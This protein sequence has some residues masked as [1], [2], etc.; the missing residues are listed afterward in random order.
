MAPELLFST[1]A[2]EQPPAAVDALD[3]A[4]VSPREV[5]WLLEQGYRVCKEI[6][7]GSNGTVF[8]AVAV[9]TGTPVALKMVPVAKLSSNERMRL[10]REILTLKNVRHRG[11]VQFV[12][13]L[14][15]DSHVYIVTELMKEDLFERTTRRTLTEREAADVAKQIL[16]TLRFLHRRGVY[17]RDIKLENIMVAE[18]DD[19]KN[20]CVKLVDFGGVHISARHVPTDEDVTLQTNGKDGFGTTFYLPPEVVLQEDYKP[21]AVDV[22]G[23]GVV[24]YS[25]MT[26]HFPFYGSSNSM[27]YEMIVKREPTFEEPEWRTVSPHFKQFLRYLLRK[28][29]T[30]RATVES[31][32]KALGR[33]VSVT[34]DEPMAVFSPNSVDRRPV[35]KTPP[36][37]HPKKKAPFN[38]LFGRR[39][40]SVGG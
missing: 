28:D 14:E 12:E 29:D 32:L 13:A 37:G 38:G 18:S 35:S 22:W 34:C 6:A 21:A 8:R 27:V 7:A 26:G 19:E 24:L 17:H 30:Q 25:A 3:P 4:V 2:F 39:R 40:A 20:A 36:H 1:A 16:Q 33:A 9:A 31:A 10:R 15:S 11:I 5:S 23:L